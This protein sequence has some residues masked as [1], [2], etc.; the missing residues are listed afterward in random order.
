MSKIPVS[1][2]IALFEQMKKEKWAYEWG[3]AR[4]GCVDCSGAFTYAARKLGDISVSHSSNMIPRKN[5]K[6]LL[7]LSEAKPGYAVLKH[8]N[9]FES[10]ALKRKYNDGLGNFKHIGL[11]SRDGGHVLEAKGSKYGFIESKLNDSWYCCG[12]LDFI[13]YGEE[14][15]EDIMPDGQVVDFQG[16]YTVNVELDSWLNV[17]ADHGTNKKVIRKLYAGNTV[18]VIDYYDNWYK[19]LLD[20]GTE[21]GWVYAKYL[22]PVE[23]VQDETPA[24][25]AVQIALNYRFIITDEAGN[26]FYPVGGFTTDVEFYEDVDN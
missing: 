9:E 22:N 6:E 24:E 17:R 16:Y 2:F 15:K 14:V 13:N 20:G 19:I 8:S 5:M 4:K 12:P 23:V 7:P 10:D 18:M 1:D 26:V 11:V 21:T 25:E 3:A